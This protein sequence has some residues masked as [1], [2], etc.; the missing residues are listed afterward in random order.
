VDALA[1]IRR[2]RAHELPVGRVHADRARRVGVDVEVALRVLD[3]HAV[4]VAEILAIGRLHPTRDPLVAVRR[5]P[6]DH[7]VV[8]RGGGA[9]NGERERERQGG[10]H[11]VERTTSPRESLPPAPFM[12]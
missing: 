12:L 11:V 3:D 9:Q 7:R 5:N 2:E 1:L 6:H 10:H 8:G 4:R